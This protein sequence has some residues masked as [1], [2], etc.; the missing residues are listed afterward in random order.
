MGSI[1]KLA[2]ISTNCPRSP[3]YQVAPI[4]PEFKLLLGLLSI[5]FETNPKDSPLSLANCHGLMNFGSRDPVCPKGYAGWEREATRAVIDGE[6]PPKDIKVGNQMVPE[7]VTPNAGEDGLGMKGNIATHT[8]DTDDNGQY[9][10]TFSVC[11]TACPGTA[12]TTATQTNSDTMPNNGGTYPL[13]NST[14]TYACS[15]IKINGALTP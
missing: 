10:D 3:L 13:T 2:G 9:P 12:T 6:S 4:L 14:I 7:T 15:S 1:L 11:S 5:T 8:G